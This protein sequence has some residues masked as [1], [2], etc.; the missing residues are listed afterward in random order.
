MKRTKPVGKVMH[1]PT[2]GVNSK[3]ILKSGLNDH[4]K[5]FEAKGTMV[6]STPKSSTKKV[7]SRYKENLSTNQLKSGTKRP[8]AK[9]WKTK[10]EKA[11]RKVE[12]KMANIIQRWWRH[13][14][15][16]RECLRNKI[17]VARKA[18]EERKQ[19]LIEKSLKSPIK[20][21]Y[22]SVYEVEN[23]KEDLMNIE[24]SAEKK[25]SDELQTA[26]FGKFDLELR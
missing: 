2:T 13:I 21:Q 15:Q 6:K 18:L 1:R 23:S 14:L 11:T 3:K 26:C 16:E 25:E 8:A 22:T 12:T 4:E 20:A 5:E 17:I 9:P 7:A 24:K 10:S 19:K